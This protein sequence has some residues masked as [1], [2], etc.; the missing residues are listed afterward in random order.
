MGRLY[1]CLT[2]LFQSTVRLAVKSKNTD[3]LSSTYALFGRAVSQHCWGKVSQGKDLGLKITKLQ[4][5]R[6]KLS[7]LMLGVT[8][9]VSKVENHTLTSLVALLQLSQQK[10][11]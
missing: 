3:V 10:T 6:P 11:F 2:L 8:D 1:V 4:Q 5:V 9:L 7:H